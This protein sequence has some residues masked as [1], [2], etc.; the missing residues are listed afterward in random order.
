M[1]SLRDNEQGLAMTEGVIVVA[2][3]LLIWMGLIALHR[4]YDGRL[5]A[6][7]ESERLVLAKAAAGCSGEN[8][9]DL[10]AEAGVDAELSGDTGDW[11]AALGGDQ[12]FAWSHAVVA[13]RLVVDGIPER[14]GGPSRTVKG[15]QRMLCNMEPIDSLT[16]LIADLVSDALGLDW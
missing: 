12:P 10:T 6:Q 4:M 15:R 3:F 16:D 1:R 9:A 13:V 14:L 8:V 7:V 11:L 2:F 5:S